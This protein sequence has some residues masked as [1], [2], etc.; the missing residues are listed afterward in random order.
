MN[1]IIISNVNKGNEENKKEYKKT[2]RTEVLH[3]ARG[4]DN[5]LLSGLFCALWGA[6]QHPP[7]F[8]PQEEQPPERNRRYS[9]R[10]GQG[11]PSFGRDT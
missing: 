3:T 6:E 1:K 10:K 4:L 8:A 9:R 11:R 7:T 5:S 2:I